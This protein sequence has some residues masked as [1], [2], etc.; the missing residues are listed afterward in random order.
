MMP[1]QIQDAISVAG[2]RRQRLLLVVGQP[3]SGKTA[4]LQEIAVSHGTSVINVNLRLSESLLDLTAKQ[5]AVRVN[6]ILSALADETPG[7]LLLFDNIELLFGVELHLDPLA[8][9]QGLSRNRTLIASW[10]GEHVGNRLT[11][12]E[13]FHPEFRH[14]DDPDAVVVPATRPARAAVQ[15]AIPEALGETEDSQ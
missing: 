13:P 9:L 5:R 15:N 11:Y 14:Y 2:T 3:R 7:E 4:M 1:E 6:R 8:L 10:T 12:A